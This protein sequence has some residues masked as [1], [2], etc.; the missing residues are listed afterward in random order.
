LGKGGRN[1]PENLTQAG[2]SFE[3]GER[4]Y[5]TVKKK[6]PHQEID[7][8]GLGRKIERGKKQA[9]VNRVPILAGT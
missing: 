1:N 2:F 4:T 9:I 6:R 5:Q 7:M 8:L 3:E